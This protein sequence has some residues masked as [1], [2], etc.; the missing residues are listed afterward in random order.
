M[1]CP[2]KSPAWFTTTRNGSGALI[3]NLSTPRI[4][5]RIVLGRSGRCA[6]SPYFSRMAS[7]VSKMEGQGRLQ[8]MT[9]AALLHGFFCPS[10]TSRLPAGACVGSGHTMGAPSHLATRKNRFLVV[11]AP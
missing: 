11:G 1:F 6:E 3:A 5:R 2:R 4:T 9:S 7:R 8:S 10:S